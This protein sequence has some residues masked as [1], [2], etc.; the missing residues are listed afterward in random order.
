[1]LLLISLLLQPNVAD[2]FRSHL[3]KAAVDAA[4]VNPFFVFKDHCSWLV[5]MVLFTQGI[6]SAVQIP[7]CHS[8]YTVTHFKKKNINMLRYLYT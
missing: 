8:C 1:M 3:G 5:D 6:I 2:D 7:Y 4:K